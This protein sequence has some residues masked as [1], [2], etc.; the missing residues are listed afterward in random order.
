MSRMGLDPLFAP[1]VAFEGETANGWLGERYYITSGG[2][3]ATA[4]EGYLFGDPTSVA[5]MSVV[6]PTRYAASV[7]ESA[8]V[9]TRPIN[10]DPL[11]KYRVARRF[12][13]RTGL[14]ALENLQRRLDTSKS[15]YAQARPEAVIRFLAED[16]G[17]G[18]LTTARAVGVTP[19]A[20]RKWRRGEAAKPDHRGKLAAFAAMSSLLAEVGL[21]DPASWLDIPISH[22]STITPLDL[23]LGGRSDIVLL[24]ASRLAEPHEALDLFD[25]QWRENYPVDSEFDV[26]TLSDGS[27]SAFPRRRTKLT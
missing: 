23:F 1:S 20:V 21:H 7:I 17:I 16:L 3:S 27:R 5:S 12:A 14:E 4:P 24:L 10:L 18:Q 6:S 19:T 9:G 26:V 25:A 8:E 22:Q 13:E 15:N 2:Q 11:A